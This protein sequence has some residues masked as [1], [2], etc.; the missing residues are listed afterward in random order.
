MS[1]Y[2]ENVQNV[3]Q[4]IENEIFEEVARKLCDKYT[5]PICGGNLELREDGFEYCDSCN[6]NTRN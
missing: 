2:S 4:I 6:Y 3:I 1:I 5:C